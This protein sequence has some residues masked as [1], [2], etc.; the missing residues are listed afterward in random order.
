VFKNLNLPKKLSYTILGCRKLSYRKNW[1]IFVSTQ[2]PLS[3]SLACYITKKLITNVLVGVMWPP[4]PFDDALNLQEL[5]A[6]VFGEKTVPTIVEEAITT[7]SVSMAV[8]VN[9]TVIE[10]APADHVCPVSIVIVIWPTRVLLEAVA[11]ELLAE[12]PAIVVL[13]DA[14]KPASE[15]IGPWTEVLDGL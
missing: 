7:L 3:K 15:V 5:F 9:D 2:Y 8:L 1:L 14:S 6:I 11:V 13:V 10:F 12:V 4:E